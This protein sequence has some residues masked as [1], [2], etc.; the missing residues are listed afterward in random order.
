MTVPRIEIPRCE[1]IPKSVRRERQWVNW[2]YAMRNGRLT[3]PPLLPDDWTERPE[4]WSSFEEATTACDVRPGKIGLGL[5]VGNGIVGIDLDGCID[6]DGELHGIARD[7][8]ALETYTE[9]S[10]SGRGLRAFIRGTIPGSKNLRKR[11]GGIPG[12]EIYD[13]KRYLTVTGKRCGTATELRDGPEA[14]AA[15]DAFY[16]KWFVG[17]PKIAPAAPVINSPE[18]ERPSDSEILALLSRV[19]NGARFDR[20]WA[21][22]V[23]D[24]PSHSEADFAL[25]RRLYY[26]TRDR[27]QIDRLFRQSG[28]MRPKW[29]E[30]HGI[31][32]YGEITIRNAITKGGRVYARPDRSREDWK[33][34]ACGTVSLACAIYMFR[35]GCELAPCLYMYLAAHDDHSRAWPSRATMAK[36]FGVPQSSIDRA[37]EKLKRLRMLRTNRTFNGPN[38]LRLVRQLSPGQFQEIF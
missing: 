15:L 24:Y 4:T 34:M 38:A 18:P 37:I 3:K 28:L 10:P 14:Q 13:S 25:C 27:V 22:D 32:T 2:K 11:G 31:Q 36:D 7:L 21:G 29:D 30:R 12:R 1:E 26:F 33:V 35:K 19:T 20:L 9:T 23:S 17:A 6:E 16:A 8:L 5:I